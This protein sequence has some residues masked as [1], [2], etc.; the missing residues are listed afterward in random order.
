MLAHQIRARTALRPPRDFVRAPRDEARRRARHGHA[1]LP[2]RDTTPQRV[3]IAPRRRAHT[4]HYRGNNVRRRGHV[5]ARTACRR[6]WGRA[7]HATPAVRPDLR[8]AVHAG[9][10]RRADG[11]LARAAGPCARAAG[12]GARAVAQRR[13]EGSR[14]RRG[15]RA[16]GA[17]GTS[18]AANQSQ[19][20]AASHAVAAGVVTADEAEAPS[21]EASGRST[22]VCRKHCTS[23]QTQTDRGPPVYYSC[24]RVNTPSPTQ[25]ILATLA[26]IADGLGRM[27][28]MPSWRWRWRHAARPPTPPALG[29]ARAR[30]AAWSPRRGSSPRPRL[31]G[32][33]YPQTSS[34][35]LRA[36]TARR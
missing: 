13:E 7:A 1:H 35:L 34:R 9:Q 36:S 4:E 32:A 25:C 2:L 15:G 19:C 8:A 6:R 29:R 22:V 31:R 10:S 24:T 11:R 23:N 20:A 30:A 27:R 18:R 3:R 17:H 14:R 16:G 12:R 33:R 26:H 5:R 28:A 21:P